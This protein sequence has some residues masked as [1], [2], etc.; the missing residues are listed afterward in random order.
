MSPFALVLWKVSTM[1]TQAPN[2]RLVFLHAFDERAAMEARDRGYLSYVAAELENGSQHALVFYD[3]VRLN[4]DLE[5]ESKLRHPCVANPGMVVIPEVTIE[6]MNKAVAILAEEGFFNY[7]QPIQAIVK[8]DP[9]MV[10]TWP[11]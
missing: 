10:F 8:L 2:V 1:S 11:P 7:L 6:Y 3:P 5:E 4:Q 9:A